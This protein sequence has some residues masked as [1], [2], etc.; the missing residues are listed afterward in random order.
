[1]TQTKHRTAVSE[2]KAKLNKRRLMI[3]R[4]ISMWGNTA[5]LNA[6]PALALVLAAYRS[7]Y[8]ACMLSVISLSNLSDNESIQ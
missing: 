1:M 6:N 3:T 8:N 2:A 5:S 4:F 7:S